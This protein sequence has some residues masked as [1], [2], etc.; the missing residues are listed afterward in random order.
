M[1]PIG[2]TAFAP[3]EDSDDYYVEVLWGG[4]WGEA[5]RVGWGSTGQMLIKNGLWRA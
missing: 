1:F 3:Y 5:W 2:E 4:L